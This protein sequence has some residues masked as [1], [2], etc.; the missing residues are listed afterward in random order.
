MKLTVLNWNWG[1]K[2]VELNFYEGFEYFT[3]EIFVQLFAKQIVISPWRGLSESRYFELFFSA[4][5]ETPPQNK[6]ALTEAPFLLFQTF[7]VISANFV[8]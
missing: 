3:Q 4:R 1:R 2:G 5:L 6:S 7:G 8:P